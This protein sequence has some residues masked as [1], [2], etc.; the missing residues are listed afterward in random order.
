MIKCALVFQHM[1]DEPPGLFGDFLAE[2]GT[3]LDVVMLHRGEDIPSL[4]PYDFLL[5]MGGA[6]DVWETEAHPWLLHEK[7]AIKEWAINRNR[8]FLGICLGLQLLAEALG[9][10]VGL[11][12]KAEVGVCDVKL[13]ALGRRHPVTSGLKPVMPVM[14][15]HHAEVQQLPESAEVL[16]TSPTTQVQIMSVADTL[17]ATQ[18]HAELNAP[19]V[20]RW[21]HIPQY[22]SWLEEALG[23]DAYTKVRAKALPLMPEMAAMSRMLLTNLL[24]GKA[25]RKAA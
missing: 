3:A 24:D 5:V 13:S 4:A 25:L 21:A 20:E 18:F 6:M 7:Q 11:S 2:R 19:L 14:Q 23:A 22:I 16:A 12:S 8:P 1:D 9:G 17:L 10:K 15:W